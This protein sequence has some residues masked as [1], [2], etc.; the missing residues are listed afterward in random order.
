MLKTTLSSNFT[1]PNLSTGEPRQDQN[2]VKT[3]ANVSLVK[4]DCPCT[5][6]H[7]LSQTDRTSCIHNQR[8]LYLFPQTRHRSTLLNPRTKPFVSVSVSLGLLH[9]SPAPAFIHTLLRCCSHCAQYNS[10]TS[11]RFRVLASHFSLCLFSPLP[12]S[13]LHLTLFSRGFHRDSPV[14]SW[15]V[16]DFERWRARGRGIVIRRF[17]R[18][19]LRRFLPHRRR[20]R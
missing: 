4:P 18:R 11:F 6:T 20:S 7:S 19:R 1:R 13:L 17:S 14:V 12:S 16:R 2:V 9:P 15:N 8:P 10:T 3:R 5:E